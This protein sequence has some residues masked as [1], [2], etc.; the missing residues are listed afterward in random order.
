MLHSWFN[1]LLFTMLLKTGFKMYFELTNG[2]CIPLFH[3]F[4]FKIIYLFK[5]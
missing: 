4:T 5:K 2:M 1:V 3:T